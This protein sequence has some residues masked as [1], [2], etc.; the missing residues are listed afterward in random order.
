[1]ADITISEARKSYPSFELGPIDLD[2]KTGEFFGIFGPP[3]SGKTSILRMILGLLDADTGVVKIGGRD[4]TGLKV[5]ERNLSMVFQNLALFPHMT[6]QE[7]ITFPLTEQNVKAEEVKMRLDA[8]AKVLHI[9]H[10]LHKNPAQMSGGERQ[11]IALGRAFI[12]DSEAMLLDEPIA[13]LDARL[14]EEMRIELKRLQ[15]EKK[16]TF[17]YVSHDEEEVLAISDRVAIVIDGQIAQ[18]GTPTE[19]YDYPKSI[20]VGGVVGSPPMNFFSG[21]ISEKSDR[22]ICEKFQIA[23]VEKFS[24]PED[25]SVTLGVRP[26]DL[27]ITDKLD[28]NGFEVDVTSSEPL[29]SY[30]V[31]NA[32]LDN[33]DLKIRVQ[34]QRMM[35]MGEKINL[36]VD[37][38]KMHIFDVN[39]NR[40]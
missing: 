3:S 1:M 15:R 37:Q 4:S 24:S 19:I 9:E 29:G 23:F 6:G 20:S 35:S 8:V 25:S 27:W 12:T 34:G 11:R 13:A 32:K 28:E 22:F 39:G 7:N 26:E 5:D 30:T 40:I 21:H 14:R 2:I 31:I 16:Q 18:V 38:R 10:I 33:Q 17:I 36:L